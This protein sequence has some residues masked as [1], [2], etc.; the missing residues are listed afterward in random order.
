MVEENITGTA[1]RSYQQQTLW[2]LYRSGIPIESIA[3]QLDMSL[4]EVEKL[5][6]K[7]GN[8]R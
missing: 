5:I 8:E 1:T 4:E 7:I 3:F 2:N 6:K